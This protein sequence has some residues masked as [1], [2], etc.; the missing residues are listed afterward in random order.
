M[1]KPSHPNVNYDKFWQEYY[2]NGYYSATRKYGNRNIKNW[3]IR[4]AINFIT[5][6][7]LD[8]AIKKIKKR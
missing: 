8:D 5:L 3:M 6:L 1:K 4:M 2:K 7:K